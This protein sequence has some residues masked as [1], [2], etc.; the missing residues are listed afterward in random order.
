[1]ENFFIRYSSSTDLGSKEWLYSRKHT[2]RED[3]LYDEHGRKILE[4][5]FAPSYFHVMAFEHFFVDENNRMYLVNRNTLEIVNIGEI[6]DE[7][8]AIRVS[9]EERW[10]VVVTSTEILMFDTYIE[11]KKS[12]GAEFKAFIGVEWTDHDVFAIFTRHKIFFY[13]IGLEKVA[14]SG[15]DKYIGICWRSKYNVFACCTD[16]CIRFIEPNGLEHG[17]PLDERCDRLA[18]LSDEDLL[19]TVSHGA[20]EACVKVLYTK[21]FQWYRKA[22][23]TVRGEFVAV[24]DNAILFKHN[25][26]LVR[27]FLFRERTHCGSEY[28]VIDGASV[29]YTDFALRIIP[30]PLFALRIGCD[31]KVID[32]SP[33]KGGGV[34]LHPSRA[35]VFEIRDEEF[36]ER[37]SLCLSNRFDSVTLFNDLIV[38]KKDNE[39][40]VRFLGRDLEDVWIR[41]GT[42]ARVSGMVL[43]ARETMIVD[44]LVSTTKKYDG[45]QVIKCYNFNERLCLVLDDGSVIHDGDVIHV[46]IDVA[47]S[48]EVLITERIYV[49]NDNSFV[50]GGELMENV[51]SFLV[52]D[53][54]LVVTSRESCTFHLESQQSSCQVDP[55]LRLLCMAGFK[56]IGETRHGTLETFTPRLYTLALVRRMLALGNYEKAVE[57]C[58]RHVVSFDVFLD[59]RLDLGR[60]VECCRDVHLTSLFNEAL[61]RLKGFKFMLK[62][63]MVRR[64]RNVFDPDIVLE[65]FSGEYF[66]QLMNRDQA[67]DTNSISHL[68]EFDEDEGCTNGVS[69]NEGSFCG[70]DTRGFFNELLPVLDMERNFAFLIF[71]FV[72]LKRIDLALMMCRNNLK[73]GISHIL[74]ITTVSNV[75]DAAMGS[76]DREFVLEVMKACQRDTSDFVSLAGECTGHFFR[77]RMND[78][79]ENRA[80]ALYHLSRMQLVE[81][82]EE[83]I[84]KHKL[85][86]E[87]LMYEVCGISTKEKG[88]Y[89]DVCARLSTSSRALALFKLAGNKEKALE[90]AVS[91]LFWREAIELH[92]NEK[93]FCEMLVTELTDAERHH[94]AAQLIEEFIGEPRRAFVEYVKARSMQDALRLCLDPEYL[95]RECRGHLRERLLVLDDLKHSFLKYTQRLKSIEERDEDCLSETSFSYTENMH[96]K[97]RLRNRPGGK[98]EREFVLDKIRCIGVRLVSWRDGNEGLLAVFKELGM[99][100]CEEAHNEAFQGFGSIFRTK[101]DD[102]FDRERKKLH[103]P[104]RPVVEKP[105]L[106]RW[107]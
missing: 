2:T 93:E 37:K 44:Q 46:G 24:E 66:D 3:V 102:I 91:G 61:E 89:Y 96:C 36:V 14:E 62:S 95:R 107:L 70:R 23:K 59:H 73:E 60:F 29:L 103:D 12:I 51:T 18:F 78:F 52:N 39:F 77:F 31:E 86:D 101:I 11:F 80:D 63:E 85:L 33:V 25:S 8:L 15:E 76:F 98:Y 4:L 65:G 1:M 71:L 57:E 87:A 83:Y 90:T 40:L 58:Q 10:C 45:L 7:I 55:G 74:T 81:M 38:L 9:M 88:F 20:E 50:A 35:V 53:Y 47:K 17:T 104:D 56:V 68:I 16:E 26:E 27:L 92:G 34:I 42:M 84:R 48:F 30:S 69:G 43:D 79:L 94:E 6:R 100:D 19:V 32:V 105:K 64:L 82:E 72:K 5:P 49:H 99:H 97:N 106:D 67:I 13:D 54:G 28:Y 21:N 22:E 41:R 75:V